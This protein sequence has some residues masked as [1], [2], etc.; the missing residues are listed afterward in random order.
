[1][2]PAVEAQNLNYNFVNK[3]KST[4]FDTLKVVI[5]YGIKIISIMAF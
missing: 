3:L 4:E 2:A 1:M 5:S